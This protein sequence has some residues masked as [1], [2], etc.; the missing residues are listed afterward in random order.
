MFNVLNT[1]ALGSPNGG[2]GNAAFGTIITAG[3]PRIVRFVV[4]TRF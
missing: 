3:D 4:K 2:V 1:P